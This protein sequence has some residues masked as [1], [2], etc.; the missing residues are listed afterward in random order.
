MEKSAFEQMSGAYY[1]QGDYFLPN[2]AVPESAPVGIWGYR[3][4]CYLKKRRQAIYTAM[5]LSGKLN[6]YLVEIDQQAQEMFSQLVKQI[7]DHEG[8]TE[9]LKASDQLEWVRKM[10]NIQNRATEI[11]NTDLIYT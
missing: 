4:L 11:V 3:H 2:L 5:L 9:H 6:S 10:N 8:I 7:A 1:Q